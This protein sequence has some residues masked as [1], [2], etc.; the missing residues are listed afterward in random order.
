MGC[1]HYKSHF[2]K[3]NPHKAIHKMEGLLY[4]WPIDF[5]LDTLKSNMV[6]EGGYTHKLKAQQPHI[7]R[8]TQHKTLHVLDS[9]LRYTWGDPKSNREGEEEWKRWCQVNIPIRC[10]FRF[11]FVEFLTCLDLSCLLKI[12]GQNNPNITGALD[13]ET[14][15]KSNSLC[16]NKFWM[17][18]FNEIELIFR[19]IKHK[20]IYL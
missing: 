20:T 9:K 8:V 10:S 11:F 14:S 19:L 7:L 12:Y 15:E 4:L 17:L 5:G 6:L 18:H 13:W 16:F 2:G 3:A 1:W